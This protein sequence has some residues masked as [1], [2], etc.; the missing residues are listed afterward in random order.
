[1]IFVTVNERMER[2][3]KILS[4]KMGPIVYLFMF[5][6]Y[7]LHAILVSVILCSDSSFRYLTT[8]WSPH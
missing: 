1:M 2:F 7:G 6:E 8:K 5:V 3:I 4:F